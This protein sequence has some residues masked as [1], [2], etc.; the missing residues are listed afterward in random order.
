ML[1]VKVVVTDD[2]EAVTV[3]R[4]TTATAV[5][6]PE[7]IAPEDVV[8]Q[9][10]DVCTDEERRAIRAAFGLPL[11]GAVTAAMVALVHYVPDSLFG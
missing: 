8:A 4:S 3:V 10:P 11:T 5:L 6:L 7:G 2:V 1:D 9:I